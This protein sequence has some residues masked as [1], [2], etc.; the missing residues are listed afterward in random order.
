MKL[1]KLTDEKKK[2]FAIE[3][4]NKELKYGKSKNFLHCAHC[5][6]QFMGSELNETMTAR[7]Y[8]MYEVS[9]YPFVYPDGTRADI[10]VVW[11][12][13]CNRKVWD[14]RHLTNLY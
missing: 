6:K 12:K 8:G 13:R 5:I 2:E 14:S 10:V 9:G 4:E 3:T 11:C 1:E 7:D